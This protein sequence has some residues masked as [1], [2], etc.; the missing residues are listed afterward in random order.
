MPTF[1]VSTLEQLKNAI[2]QANRNKKADKIIIQGNI[3]WA[4]SD[5]LPDI[6]EKKRVTIVGQVGPDNEAATLDA[7]SFGRHFF[8]RSGNVILQNLN[9]VE[10][11]ANGTSGADG[12]G[13]GGGA[14]LG[15]SLFVYGGNVTVRSST[16]NGNS[17]LGGNGAASGE[18]GGPGGGMGDNYTPGANGGPD[19]VGQPG[20][21]GSG[22][23]G[24]GYS[25]NPANVYGASGGYGGFGGGGGGGGYTFSASGDRKGGYGGYGGFGGGGGGG[26]GSNYAE[27]GYA[28]GKGGYAG[29]YGGY[30]N[31]NGGGGGAGLGGAIFV[32][33]GSLTIDRSTFGNNSASGGEGANGG[34]DGSGHGGA[35]FALSNL[36]N[37]TGESE[38]QNGMPE[39]LPRVTF[40]QAKFVS[41][42][43]TSGE[44]AAEFGFLS[45]GTVYENRDFF[46]R[47]YSGLV[48]EGDF[49][50]P[51]NG[52]KK[53]NRL[54]GTNGND[55][56]DGKGG[57][58]R[59]NGRD[60]DDVLIG[61]NGNDILNGDT[62][63]DIMAGGKGNDRY[64][65]DDPGDVVLEFA[66]EGQDTVISSLSTYALPEHVENLTL[67]VGGQGTGNDLNNVIKGSVS[68]DEL[69]GGLGNDKLNGGDGNDILFGGEAV[70]GTEAGEI[71]IL[72]GG[73]GNDT[74]RLFSDAGVAYEETGSYAHI[75]DFKVNQDRV[76]LLGAP[77][78]YEIAEV[79]LGKKVS[80]VGIYHVDGDDRDLIGVL[81]GLKV[82]QVSLAPSGGVFN[83]FLPSP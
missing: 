48:V 81:Q 72:T 65:V 66:N 25:T 21:F 10:G 20:T 17:A 30:G 33:S 38:K 6:Q 34:G 55:L 44:G 47:V 54:N 82:N 73:S 7:N 1:R 78:D 41:N 46:G 51:I 62:G 58:D 70:S 69:I 16:F 83:Y 57:N 45:P 79:R 56:I 68:Q 39:Q 64:F 15:G 49:L 13:G 76:A 32:R 8:I 5:V 52:N 80:G 50:N 27:M 42:D 43:S 40:S 3:E 28:N 37:G 60:G 23:G 18:S 36:N 14:G 12:G 2:N 11:S 29:N 59:L 63:A 53:G 74:F 35:I 71:D 75:T 26:G 19:Q 61:G 31:Y 9:L 22:G 77:D 4:D 24:G 67:S